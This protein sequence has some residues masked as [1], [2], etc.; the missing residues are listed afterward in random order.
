[1]K[2]SDAASK[3][4]PLASRTGQYFLRAFANRVSREAPGPNAQLAI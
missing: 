1:M 2:S 3:G 4:H